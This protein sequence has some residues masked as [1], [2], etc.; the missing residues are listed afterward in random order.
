MNHN[1]YRRYAYS[2]ILRFAI[3]PQRQKY[4]KTNQRT[5]GAAEFPNEAPDDLRLFLKRISEAVECGAIAKLL[6]HSKY[7]IS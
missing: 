7:V 2:G 4:V 5:A 6:G 3:G 1:R